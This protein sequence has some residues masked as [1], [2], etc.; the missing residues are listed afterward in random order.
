MLWY[1]TTN[2]SEVHAVSIFWVVTSCSVVVGYQRLGGPC[3]LH[4]QGFSKWDQIQIH[5]ITDGHSVRSGIEKGLM[6]M[7]LKFTSNG[8]GVSHYGA[9]SLTSDAGCIAANTQPTHV[10]TVLGPA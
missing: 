6:A 10:V 2:V 7:F 1:D 5:F 9:P 8:I 3:C 4:L